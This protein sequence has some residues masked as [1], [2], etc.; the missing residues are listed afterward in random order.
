ME[1]RRGLRQRR[2]FPARPVGSGARPGRLPLRAEQEGGQGPL[3]RLHRASAGPALAEDQRAG[4]ELSQRHV[5][6]S[7]R[8]ERLRGGL[9]GS[10]G[11]GPALHAGAGRRSDVQRAR[12]LRHLL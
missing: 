12:V 10:G 5:G 8:R 4:P 1:Q 6:P 7:G 9:S 2:P 11:S 3:R